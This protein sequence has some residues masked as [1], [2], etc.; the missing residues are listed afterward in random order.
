MKNLKLNVFLYIM[1][2]FETPFYK[3]MQ[4]YSKLVTFGFSLYLIFLIQKILFTML[5][6]IL[7]DQI[8][9]KKH[10]QA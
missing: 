2:M 8:N 7:F 3:K 1:V 9:N 10:E 4:C 5:H 6:N